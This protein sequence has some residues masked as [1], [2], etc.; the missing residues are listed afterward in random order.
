MNRKKLENIEHLLESLSLE[1]HGKYTEFSD[2]TVILTVPVN[3]AETEFQSIKGYIADQ[4]TYLNQITQMIILTGTVCTLH[5]H[6]E[7]DFKELLKKN[8]TMV[9]SKIT[10]TDED[11]LEVEAA[12]CYEYATAEEV[13]AMIKEVAMTTQQLKKELV[14]VNTN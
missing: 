2:N 5:D 4:N 6:P 12:T 7:L 9:Y 11:Y 8:Y 10:I 13:E 14:G 1:L 3:K